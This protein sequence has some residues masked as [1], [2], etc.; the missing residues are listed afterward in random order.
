MF[1]FTPIW[2]NDQSWLL[3]FPMGWNHQLAYVYI[4]IFPLKASTS[5]SPTLQKGHCSWAFKA[6]TA[7]LPR[8]LVQSTKPYCSSSRKVLAMPCG[9]RTLGFPGRFLER[10]AIRSWRMTSKMHR[11]RMQFLQF[12]KSEIRKLWVTVTDPARL[13]MMANSSQI[14]LVN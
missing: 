9:G 8:M 5:W 12:D 2:G 11:K 6:P 13:A 4:Y 1:I 10:R 7:S 3:F 14:E